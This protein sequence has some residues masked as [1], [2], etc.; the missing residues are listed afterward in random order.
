MYF[1][2]PKLDFRSL[3]AGL[4]RYAFSYIRMFC[5]LHTRRFVV[6]LMRPCCSETFVRKYRYVWWSS[7]IPPIFEDIC[8]PWIRRTCIR[9]GRVGA[10]K[11]TLGRFRY[12]R[13]HKLGVVHCLQLG[14]GTSKSLQVFK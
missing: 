11:R 5:V 9:H 8:R 12:G 14:L 13:E 10:T 2:P 7:L 4:E 6:R 1:F 3:C